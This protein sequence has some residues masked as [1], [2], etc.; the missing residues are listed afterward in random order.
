MGVVEFSH[1]A[2]RIINLF[3]TYEDKKA[4]RQ[5]VRDA[6]NSDYENPMSVIDDTY[7]HYFLLE[8]LLK[9][10]DDQPRDEHGRWTASVGGAEAIMEGVKE[11]EKWL[12]E[13]GYL[14]H[15]NGWLRFVNEVY[16]ER[17]TK[18]LAL[19]YQ[20]EEGLGPRNAMRAAEAE[21][22]RWAVATEC[23]KQA[24]FRADWEARMAKE[25]PEWY[26]QQYE[27]NKELGMQQI[28]EAYDTGRIA[29]ALDEDSFKQMLEDGRYKSQF[30]TKTTHGTKDLEARKVTED[31]AMGLPVDMK[32]SDRPIYGFIVTNTEPVMSSDKE[33]WK[34]PSE[35]LWRDAL[36]VN[37]RNVEHYGEIRIVLNDDVRDRTTATVDDSLRNGR[38]ALPLGTQLTEQDHAFNGG[39]RSGFVASGAGGGPALRY[40]E[41]QTVGGV[42]S[43]DIAE[44]HAP[45]EQ[46]DFIQSLLDEHGLDVP[47]IAREEDY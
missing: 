36:S 29:I 20:H 22:G 26:A 6:L 28:Q 41:S 21:I 13:N 24:E 45:A 18:E 19:K 4:F 16:E 2:A 7:R 43:S 42:R 5:A 23:A 46:V 47:V 11:T 33:Y 15:Y 1:K 17:A 30:E 12:Q 10:R 39:Q 31:I 9:Y 32:T 37:S 34:Q 25:E 3:N 8:K 44:I 40:I 27:A 14:S 35:G 38:F